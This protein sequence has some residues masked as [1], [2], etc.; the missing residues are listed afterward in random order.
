MYLLGTGLIVIAY[1]KIFVH[2]WCTRNSDLHTVL[3]RR[4]VKLIENRDYNLQ[5]AFHVIY[6][7]KVSVSFSY[8]YLFTWNQGSNGFFLNSHL[9]NGTW[10]F[11]ETTMKII[12]QGLEEW[13]KKNFKKLFYVQMFI[14][15]MKKSRNFN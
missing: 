14:L 4:V 6:W 10:W 15:F 7:S 3:F 2:A 5:F 13:Q 12:V 11:G 8:K 9:C 1:S